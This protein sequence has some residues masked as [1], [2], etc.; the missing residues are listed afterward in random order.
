MLNNSP[1]HN[2]YIFI[3][4]PLETDMTLISHKSELSAE[5]T[6][7]RIKLL[8]DEYRKEVEAKKSTTMDSAVK[9]RSSIQEYMAKLKTLT[10]QN[11]IPLFREMVTYVLPFLLLL[12]LLLLVLI[13]HMVLLHVT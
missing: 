10:N 8:K 13:C 6:K 5:V 2:T 12:L 3:K 7:D 1:S 11:G 9:R 4:K